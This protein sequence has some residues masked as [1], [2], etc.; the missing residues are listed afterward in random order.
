MGKLR[1][2]L[3]AGSL[4]V[5]T[6]CSPYGFQKPVA[7]LGTSTRTLVSSV[8]SYHQALVDEDTA[9]YRRNLVLNRT[10]VVMAPSCDDIVKVT[11][12]E[13]TEEDLA[14]DKAK[15]KEKAEK[16]KADAANGK[17]PAV[18]KPAPRVPCSVYPQ[19]DKNTPRPDPYPVEDLV[20]ATTRLT[21]YMEALAAVTN[22]AD[23]TDYDAAVTKL[24]TAVTAV[25]TA[26]GGPAGAAVGAGINL[27]GW[28]LG[29]A[30]DIQR[31]EA[32]KAAVN[33]VDKPTGP[34]NKKPFNTVVIAIANSIDGLAQHRREDLQ[35]QMGKRSV[36]LG[37]GSLS[38]ADY[39]ARM[40]EV[41]SLGAQI[42]ALNQ[43]SAIAPAN[44]LMKA[45][46]QLVV[47]V[48]QSRPDIGDLLTTLGT[49]KDKVAALQAALKT[50]TAATSPKKG[51]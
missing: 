22:A 2:F 16:D 43:T 18:E 3:A 42:D 47:A 7:D 30:L 31:F 23:R 6:A 4:V 26:A 9:T 29:N 38:A 1:I 25:M 28:L 10:P 45:H 49:L 51:T 41:E 27:F 17:L 19:A 5:M 44:A 32:L 46:L 37:D 13:P 14:R 48:N 36:A 15:E 35:T 12:K 21:N 20:P 40:A 33:L 8:T 50:A 11:L 24:G 34:D 39:A